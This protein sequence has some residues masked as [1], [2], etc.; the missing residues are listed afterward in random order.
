V[1][2]GLSSCNATAT[3]ETYTLSLHDAL[4]ISKTG[5]KLSSARDALSA[6]GDKQIPASN[7]EFHEFARILQTVPHLI[8]RTPLLLRLDRRREGLTFP[9]GTLRILS[10]LCR[11]RF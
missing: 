1:N 11:H 8:T 2:Y 4:P 5:K 6:R 9:A 3:T 10:G 7:H